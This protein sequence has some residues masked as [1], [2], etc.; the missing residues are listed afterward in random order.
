MLYYT[1]TLYYTIQLVFPSG[2]ARRMLRDLEREV[3]IQG[4]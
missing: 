4:S 1:T 3:R 2:A